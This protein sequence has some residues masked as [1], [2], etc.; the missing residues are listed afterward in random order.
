MERF[1]ADLVK[2]F[3]G[4]RIDRREFCQDRCARRHRLRGG[5]RR[6]ARSTAR[7]QDA[8]HQSHL[9]HVPGLR[10]GAR[11]VRPSVSACE[12]T[13]GKDNGKRANLM[14]GPEPGKGGSFMV[15]RNATPH[16]Q[17]AAAGDSGRRSRLLHDLELERRARE[18]RP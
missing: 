9:L 13:P 3:E 11:L 18:R 6:Q 15:A 5:R 2:N 1:I 10:Q 4:G 16:R 14:F 7:L 17:S 8:R 12:S